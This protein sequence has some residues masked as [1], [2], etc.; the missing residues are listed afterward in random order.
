M[1]QPALKKGRETGTKLTCERKQRFRL[2]GGLN[3]GKLMTATSMRF[4]GFGRLQPAF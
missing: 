4:S 3:L 2:T 1:A